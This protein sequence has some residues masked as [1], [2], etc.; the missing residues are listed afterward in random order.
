MIATTSEAVHPLLSARRPSWSSAVEDELGRFDENIAA[1]G[2]NYGAN[3]WAT[4][5]VHALVEVVGGDRPPGQLARWTSRTVFASVSRYA[6]TSARQRLRRPGRPGREQ[7]A[8]IRVS[9][10][11]D[12]VLEVSAR[13]RSGDRYRALAAR[14]DAVDGEWR[15]TALQLG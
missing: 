13:I 12:G 8:S 15:C 7:V 1:L 5:F 9:R 6:Q 2:S 11:R 3:R 10:P 4:R 14:L